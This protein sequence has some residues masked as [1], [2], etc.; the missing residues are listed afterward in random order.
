MG[1]RESESDKMPGWMRR[2]R[3]ICYLI[4]PE[5][6]AELRGDLRYIQYY[7]TAALALVI[8]TNVPHI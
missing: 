8:L 6:R 5:G 7:N 3:G 1:L 2:A 4:L